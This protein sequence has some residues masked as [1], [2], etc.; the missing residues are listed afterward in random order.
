[1][2]YIEDH[3]AQM[4]LNLNVHM[5]EAPVGRR[6]PDPDQ[7]QQQDANAEDDESLGDVDEAFHA[8]M[9][10]VY[11]DPQVAF[12]DATRFYSHVSERFAIGVFTMNFLYRRGPSRRS[13]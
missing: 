9:G 3:G 5:P 2:C 8:V 12:N 4:D 10:N 11:H 13:I 6:P 1:M 7:D